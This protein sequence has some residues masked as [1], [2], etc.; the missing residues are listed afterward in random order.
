MPEESFTLIVPFILMAVA[1][2]SQGPSEV[3][4]PD[5]AILAPGHLVPGNICHVA[6]Y[7]S[8]AVVREKKSIFL[9]K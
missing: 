9:F 7:S 2:Q 8:K 1:Q 3:C 5:S 4:D 6:D